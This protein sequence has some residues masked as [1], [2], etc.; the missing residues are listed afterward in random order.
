[1]M[2]KIYLA[3]NIVVALFSAATIIYILK[4]WGKRK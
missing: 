1:M 3:I 4:N 2:D